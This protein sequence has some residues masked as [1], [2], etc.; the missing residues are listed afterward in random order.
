[1]KLVWQRVESGPKIIL[2]AQCQYPHGA[3]TPTGLR[4]TDMDP[5]QDWCVANKCGV[6]TSFDTFKFRDEK[7]LSMFLLK[8]G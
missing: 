5:I 7:E 4:D 3:I 6:R 1:M 8:W 2:V